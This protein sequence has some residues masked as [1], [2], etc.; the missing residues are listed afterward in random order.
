MKDCQCFLTSDSVSMQNRRWSDSFFSPRHWSRRSI[1][2]MNKKTLEKSEQ[3][4]NL[5]A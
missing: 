1:N 5:K 4:K 3:L 2:V